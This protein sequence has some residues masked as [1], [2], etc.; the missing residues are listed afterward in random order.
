MSSNRSV[1]ANFVLLPQANLLF[2]GDFF[3]GTNGWN[4]YTWDGSAAAGE[5][6]SAFDGQ[7][8]LSIQV[9]APG[10]NDWSVQ[11]NQHLGV[12]SGVYYR[13]SFYARSDRTRPLLAFL[14]KTYGDFGILGYTQFG[15]LTTDW[16]FFDRT[17]KCPVTEAQAQF[18]FDQFGLHTPDKVELAGQ[19]LVLGPGAD[20]FKEEEPLVA[21]GFEDA[22]VDAEARF[23]EAAPAGES[24]LD[25]DG[26][27]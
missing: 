3:H 1:T 6:T 9:S 20:E 19:L 24:L 16:Q 15:M 14:Q 17:F 27:G 2:N 4:L 18:A 26:G 8:A 21:A 22:V 25:V 5:I 13:A 7:P 12:E 10:P 23:D 11:L